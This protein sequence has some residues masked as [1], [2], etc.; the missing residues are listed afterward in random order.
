MLQGPTQGFAIDCRMY[1]PLI[2]RLLVCDAGDWVH[3]HSTP[4]LLP[5][6]ELG[7]SLWLPH[8]GHT[9][10]MPPYR[11]RLPGKSLGQFK[12]FLISFFLSLIQSI[13]PSTFVSPAIFPSRISVKSNANG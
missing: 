11:S 1:E 4:R 10:L 8:D 13:I 3:S 7:L 2:G 5:S 12:S 9:W 6:P